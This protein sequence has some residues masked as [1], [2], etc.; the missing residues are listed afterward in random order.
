[1]SCNYIDYIVLAWLL[2]GLLCGRRRG[3]T[4][5]VLPTIQWVLIAV[6][7]GLFYAPFGGLISQATTGA[8]TRLWSNITAYVLI[9]FAVHLFFLWLRQGLNDKLTGSD[10]FGKAEYYLGMTSGMVRFAAIFLVFCSLMHARIVTQAELAATEKMQKK[11][12]EDIRFP[13]YG[14]VQHALLKESLVGRWVEGNL[15]CVL[16]DTPAPAKPAATIAQRHDDGLNAL[17]GTA[18]R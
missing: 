14:S 6:L 4:L 12:F 7:A 3:M 2:I 17:L 10:Y 18:K 16:I 1:M 15:G 8:F 9:G 11:N 5:E 13:T